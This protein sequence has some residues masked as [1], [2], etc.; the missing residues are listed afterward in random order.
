MRELPQPPAVQVCVLA[1]PPRCWRQRQLSSRHNAPP[2]LLP[3]SAPRPS[4]LQ[5]DL[6]LPDGRLARYIRV[7][8]FARE[9]T[10]R[11]VQRAVEGGEAAGAAGYIL[12][13]RSNSGGWAPLGAFP[14]GPD[15]CPG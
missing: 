5:A 10:P 6:R 12:D 1:V 15:L 9:A 14:G 4:P 2:T 3:P 8:Y 11:A 13:L 7:L